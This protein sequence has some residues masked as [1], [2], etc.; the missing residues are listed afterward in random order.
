MASELGDKIQCS[1][2]ILYHGSFCS[3]KKQ[4]KN[5]NKELDRLCPIQIIDNL[6]YGLV[7]VLISVIPSTISLFM[8]LFPLPVVSH[9]LCH[10]LG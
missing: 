7:T 2:E 1:G 3:N 9:F 8:I 5:Y 4:Q 6:T 10:L